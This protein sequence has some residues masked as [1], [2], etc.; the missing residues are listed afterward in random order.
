[1]IVVSKHQFVTKLVSKER[2]AY[3]FL[4][5][6]DALHKK[7]KT[8]IDLVSARLKQ[9]PKWKHEDHNSLILSIFLFMNLVII[10]DIF[11]Q[12]NNEIGTPKNI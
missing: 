1:M 7:N 11:K 2:K 6:S 5:V 8:S 4:F 10:I 3:M 9:K 12:L